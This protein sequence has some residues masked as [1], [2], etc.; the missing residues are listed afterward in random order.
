MLHWVAL[1]VGLRMSIV[2]EQPHLNLFQSVS[3]RQNTACDA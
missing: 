1:T 2:F 3:V